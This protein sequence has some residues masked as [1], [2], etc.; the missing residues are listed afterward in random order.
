MAA[1]KTL[2]ATSTFTTHDAKT[3]AEVIVRAGDRLKATDPLVKGREQLFE[4]EQAERSSEEV[5]Q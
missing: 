4:A 2:V 1:P 5:R 3:N